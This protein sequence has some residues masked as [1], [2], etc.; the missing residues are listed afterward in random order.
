[1]RP[2]VSAR[3]IW[4][5]ISNVLTHR[6]D[7]AFCIEVGRPK[8]LPV[9]HLLACA[10]YWPDTAPFLYVQF[11]VNKRLTDL[12]TAKAILSCMASKH[13]S[14]NLQVMSHWKSPCN[15]R[16]TFQSHMTSW[17]K[18]WETS[19]MFLLRIMAWQATGE[20]RQTDASA[21]QQSLD[22]AYLYSTLVTA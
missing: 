17:W 10:G 7:T 13:K 14:F 18:T 12:P 15:F 4:L 8:Y 11:S 3:P 9:S 6:P 19:L 21:V 22:N 16:G 5:S 20:A 1:M 2:S